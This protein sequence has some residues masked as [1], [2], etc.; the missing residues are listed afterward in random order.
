[1]HSL[2]TTLPFPPLLLALYACATVG[3]FLSKR[4][5]VLL[6]IAVAL[7]GFLLG[8]QIVLLARP[9]VSNMME[10]L[11]YVPFVAALVGLILPKLRLV[12]GISACVILPF[13]PNHLSFEPVQAVLNSNLWLTI[14]VLMV[15]G[16]YA[17]F[18]L[19][20]IIGHL[21]LMRPNPRALS[22][23]L[24][25]L[26][27]GTF[28]LITGTILG[29]VWAGQSW[30]R[31]WDWDPKESWAFISC[32]AYL[33]LLHLYRFKKITP[34]TLAM[35]S[36]IGFI[37]I[38]FTWYGVNYILATGLHSYGFG[39]AKHHL[40][41]GSFVAFE[42]LFLGFRRFYLWEKDKKDKSL[43]ANNEK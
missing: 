15:V 21:Y 16:S 29:G 18:L 4:M 11:F 10:T 13:L 23:L 1:M 6:A 7:H 2:L 31:F 34:P 25:V 32:G 41:F 5:W 14:H 8:A 28:L 17:F 27:C 33:I 22:P 20:T 26:Y 9:P 38:L 42:G 36:V 24:K 3:I 40:L 30:G 37:F 19:A 35:G 39:E 12:G 43:R